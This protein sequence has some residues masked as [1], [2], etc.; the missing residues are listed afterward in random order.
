[1]RAD[2]AARPPLGR[3]PKRG[4]LGALG[5]ALALAVAGADCGGGPPN[6]GARRTAAPARVLLVGTFAGRR[7]GYGTI[8]AAVD[9]ARPGDWVL[10]APGDYHEGDDLAHPPA[11]GDAGAGEFGAVRITTPDIHVRGMDRASVIV[12]GTRP[13]A[14]GAPV[15]P[16]SAAPAAQDLGATGAGRRPEG[17][18]GI[19]VDRVGGVSIENLTVCNFL[20]GAA[21]AGRGV[22][23][24]GGDG[25]G[26]IGLAGYRGGY[27]TVT[28]TYAGGPTTAARDGIAASDAAGPATWDQLYASNMGGAG[29][30]LGACRQRCAITIEGAWME[31]DALGYSGTNAGGA[32]VIEHSR[33]DENDAGVETG[34]RYDTD[35]PAPQDGDCPGTAT[36][37]VT[38]TRSC[39]VFEDND[40]HDNDNPDVPR[41]AGAAGGPTGTGL[42]VSGGTGDTVMDNTFE[43]NGA[44]GVLFVSEPDTGQPVAG[45]SCAGAG[46]F[47]LPQF[48]CVFDPQGDALVH[49]AFVHNGFFANPSDADVGQ[50]VLQAGEPAN[51]YARNTLPD[52]SQPPLL[53]ITQPRCAGAISS[54]DAGGALLG[55]VLCDTGFGACP[56]GSGYPAA[57]RVELHTLPSLPS[58]PD[59]CAGVPPT[60][61]CPGG[62]PA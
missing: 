12:D 24:N 54:A 42:T 14:P 28:S 34:T 33:F 21:D 15:A 20:S 6:S 51:C 19:V 13:A 59:P 32:L 11:A 4:G 22:W 10:V 41:A 44:W 26:G 52:G 17:R 30:D 2:R 5:V 49:N 3:R 36:S 8:Q 40:V 35:P 39:W 38:H 48:G 62:R 37:P 16:C 58:M 23:W 50:I 60:P 45:Q 27:L 61:W 9:A 7:G 25:G 18:N 1:M 46:G 31:Y 29:L 57:R 47:P 43:N 55:Q 53:E 56:P